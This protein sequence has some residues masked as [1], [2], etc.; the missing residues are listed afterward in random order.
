[1][2][3]HVVAAVALLGARAETVPPAV[4]L[5]AA[6]WT[7][8]ELRTAVQSVLGQA[9]R[10]DLFLAERDVPELVLLHG[11]VRCT[12]VLGRSEQVR[13]RQAIEFRLAAAR[14]R[15]ERQ[16]ARSVAADRTAARGAPS[17]SSG[18]FADGRPAT[19]VRAPSPL[20]ADS[21][22]RDVVSRKG[23]GPVPTVDP[24]RGRTTAASE[25]AAESASGGAAQALQLIALIEA[26]I[27]PESWDSN[28]GRGTIRYYSPLHLL[29]VRNTQQAHRELGGLLGVMGNNR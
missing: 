4:E 1:M 18:P 23:S 16:R 28:G 3:T 22:A 24:T 29:V 13:L 6:P 21:S 11:A 14:E 5:A 25:T 8:P 9:R 15:L 7:A 12:T 19:N 20:G 17:P 27:Q 26:T 10:E 2:I